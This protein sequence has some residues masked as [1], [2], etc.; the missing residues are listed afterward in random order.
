M[1]GVVRHRLVIIRHLLLAL[2]PL[3]VTIGLAA[4]A[5]AELSGSHPLT[6][7]VPRGVPEAIA[8]KDE[9]TAARLVEDGAGV[10]EIGLIRAGILSSQPLLVTPLE[11]A[12][13]VDSPTAIDYLRARGA[14]VTPDLGCLASDVGARVVRRQ[15]A[16][17]AACRSGATLQAVL[18]R[19]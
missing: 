18:H 14:R 4:L 1:G 10:D 13:L 15:I 19:P 2:P 12:V 7:G 8:L 9:A 5:G 11:A 3:V 6:M 17:A 16:D